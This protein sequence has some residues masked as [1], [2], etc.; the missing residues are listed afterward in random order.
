MRRC[1][2]LLTSELWLH[3]RAGTLGLVMTE[4]GW[5]ARK[6]V[7]CE[8]VTG[9]SWPR[10]LTWTRAVGIPGT[11]IRGQLTGLEDASLLRGGRARQHRLRVAVLAGGVAG[12]V[13]QLAL[14]TRHLLTGHLLS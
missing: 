2:E 12:A 5:L 13:G 11:G 14:L 3:Q 9:W 8:V 1:D 6:R 10:A 7:R 4:R